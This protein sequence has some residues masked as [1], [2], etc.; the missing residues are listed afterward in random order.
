MVHKLGVDK[1][2]RKD[3]GKMWKDP[4]LIQLKKFL[5]FLFQL[6]ENE[7]RKSWLFSQ[8]TVPE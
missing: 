4:T 6:K 2:T 5:T 7:T 1:T 8:K 3:W